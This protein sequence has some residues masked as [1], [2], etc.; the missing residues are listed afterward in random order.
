MAMHTIFPSSDLLHRKCRLVR[1]KNLGDFRVDEKLEIGA[2]S[3]LHA[4]KLLGRLAEKSVTEGDYEFVERW[5]PLFI[6]VSMAAFASA[7]LSKS[8]WMFGIVT[9]ASMCRRTSNPV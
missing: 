8:R 4:A 6:S 5:S 1:A 3:P 2:E 7:S 9:Y